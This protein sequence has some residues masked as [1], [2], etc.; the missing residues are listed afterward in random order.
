MIRSVDGNE[1]QARLDS[2][3]KER[4]CLEVFHYLMT[5]E[6][7]PDNDTWYC[8]IPEL[9]GVW[10]NAETLDEARTGLQDVLGARVFHDSTGA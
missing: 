1:A 10:S 5:C 6:Q 8:E 9:P 2:P 7:L 3:D 4:A